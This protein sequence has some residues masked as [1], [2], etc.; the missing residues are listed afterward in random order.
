M[1]SRLTKCLSYLTEQDTAT[2]PAVINTHRRN[3]MLSAYQA[4][5]PALLNAYLMTT[6]YRHVTRYLPNDFSY[7]VGGPENFFLPKTD[8]GTILRRQIKALSD[9]PKGTSKNSGLSSNATK[10]PA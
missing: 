4:H 2:L 7:C 6:I 8:L 9:R 5:S 10:S 3:L 1:I